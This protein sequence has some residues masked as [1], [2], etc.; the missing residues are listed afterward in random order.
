MAITKRTTLSST[1][2]QVKIGSAES[3]LHGVVAALELIEAQGDEHAGMLNIPVTE[4]IADIDLL[5]EL[6]E[7]LSTAKAVA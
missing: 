2:R 3:R 5:H 1:Q 4:L 7:F 6:S